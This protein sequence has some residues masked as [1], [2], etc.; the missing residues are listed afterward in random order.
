MRC[1]DAIS[2]DLESPLTQFSRLRHDNEHLMHKLYEI[3][4][5]LQWNTNMDSPIPL[6]RVGYIISSDLQW[7]IQWHE[8]SRGFSATAEL[9]VWS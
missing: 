3:G 5:Q 7:N 1:I 8:A 9:L 4:S 6:S 2:N